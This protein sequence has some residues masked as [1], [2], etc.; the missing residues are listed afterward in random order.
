MDVPNVN[1]DV[2]KLMS[3][4][5]GETEHPNISIGSCRL[6]IIH[7]A[8]H[9]GINSHDWELVKIFYAMYNPFKE[10][11]A[12]IDEYM[13]FVN[14]ILLPYRK[15]IYFQ[16]H[17]LTDFI[18]FDISKQIVFYGQSYKKFLSNLLVVAIN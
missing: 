12:R 11:P 9:S 14:L 2:L 15:S 5:Q 1:W 17:K 4:H 18:L 6:H 7:G 16:K 10:S 8:L 3:T 13:K